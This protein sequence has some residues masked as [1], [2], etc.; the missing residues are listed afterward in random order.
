MARFGAEVR[1]VDY[2]NRIVG[3]NRHN[4]ACGHTAQN[5]G[6]FQNRQRAHQAAGVDFC[7]H[8]QG[9][10]RGDTNVHS[11]ETGFNADVTSGRVTPPRD[12][13]KRGY[14]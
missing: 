1:N 3:Q 9:V 7:I 5:L 14:V 4:C 8:V 6:G 10:P 2:G 11:V 13:A 12:I